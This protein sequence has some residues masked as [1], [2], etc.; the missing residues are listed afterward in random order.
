MTAII[1]PIS[2]APHHPARRPPKFAPA[3]DRV[4]ECGH[5]HRSHA[6]DGCH[7]A[8]F[9]ERMLVERCECRLGRGDL[10]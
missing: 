10:S 2:A 3:P 6:R 7:A 4:C 5:S 9:G 8:R 1:I